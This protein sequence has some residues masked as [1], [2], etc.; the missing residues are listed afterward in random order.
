MIDRRI[1]FG[2]LPL[3]VGVVCLG[4]GQVA[5][6]EAIQTLGWLT[7]ACGALV[8]ALSQSMHR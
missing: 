8:L 4:L 5:N 2:C 7:F 1:T 3:L 6:S